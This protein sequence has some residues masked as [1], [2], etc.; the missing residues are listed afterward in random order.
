MKELN[1]EEKA[2][3][4]DEVFSMAKEWYNNPNSSSIGKSY[5]YA[6]LPELKESK[7]SEDEGVKRILHS[8]SSKMS[9]HLRDIF[10]EEEFQCFDAWSNAWL[11]KQGELNNNEDADIL[12]RFSFYSYKDEPNVLYLSSVFVNEE[13]RNKGIGT[14]ILKIADEVSTYF[15]CNSI[16]LKTENGS[17][18]ES[19]YRKNGYK[20]LKEEGNQIWLEKQGEQKPAKYTLKQAAS[21]FLDALS[22][23]P[24]N[25]KPITDAQVITKELL[26]FLSDASSYNPNALNEQKPADTEKGTNGNDREIPIS[27]P[28]LTI[29]HA[30]EVM[31]IK[32]DDAWSEV[33]VV[34]L[35][36]SLE[37]L[38]ELKD[39]F[40]EEYG[41]VGDCINWLKSIR[42]RVQ[43][44]QKQEW[45]EEDERILKEII[46]DVKFEGYNN[47][48]QANSYK[49]INWLKF[50]KNRVQPQNTWK[51]S[52]EQLK[53]LD[54]YV[55]DFID[56]TGDYAN[57]LK[58]LLQ[59]L[60][61]L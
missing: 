45:S 12:Q 43:P 31:G 40:G 50:I 9:F 55:Y 2:R 52:D 4:Y 13:Y 36:L 61:A 33:D 51:P 24:Y 41:K 48:M 56:S 35:K 19:L 8:I 32:E 10:T 6:V 49:K 21:I 18:A 3:R 23:T 1:I 57:I 7:E 20:T 30:K 22:N 53:A 27:E 29:K 42:N 37:N 11:E 16:R 38:T 28:P 58:E 44:Q 5:L 26:R 59:Q 39:R 25:N 34:L 17:N 14:K 54:H 46:T 60:K 47:D 15:K